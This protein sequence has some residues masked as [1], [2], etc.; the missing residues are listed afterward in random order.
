MP[1]PLRIIAERSSSMICLFM[2]GNRPWRAQVTGESSG[3]VPSVAFVVHEHTFTDLL[4]AVVTRRG[5]ARGE[6]AV[7]GTRSEQTGLR[8]PS[9][10]MS[11][12]TPSRINGFLFL[13]YLISTGEPW[14]HTPHQ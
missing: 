13:T 2:R 8:Q 7:P 6:I 4:N 5:R 11:S 3:N 9:C 10:M 1:S 14:L 12:A